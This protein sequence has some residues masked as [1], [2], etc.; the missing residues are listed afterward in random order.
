MGFFNKIGHKLGGGLSALEERNRRQANLNRIRAAL[1]REECAAQ[2]EYIALGRYY[3]STLRD[4][5]NP[6]TEAHCKELERI[7]TRMNA[8]V[9]QLERCYAELSQE[10][11]KRKGRDDDEIIGEQAPPPRK[12]VDQMKDSVDQA[13]RNIKDAAVV[14]SHAAQEKVTEVKQGVL[15]SVE[16]TA[17]IISDQA[18]QAADAAALHS[19]ETGDRPEAAMPENSPPAI[20]EIYGR[21]PSTVAAQPALD[22]EDIAAN[23][24]ENDNLPFAD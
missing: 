8:A 21:A 3:Y 18:D 6:V 19:E 17:R 5:A 2:M 11:A 14:V 24:D 13:K 1:K 20:R 12:A 10:K 7:E 15:H 22:E 16:K 9:N 4:P 23:P